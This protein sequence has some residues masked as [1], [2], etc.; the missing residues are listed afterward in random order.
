MRPPKRQFPTVA[1][2]GSFVVRVSFESSPG[3]PIENVRDWLVAWMKDQSDGHGIGEFGS[4][5]PFAAYFS[6][7]PQ[8]ELG[9]LGEL[10]LLLRGVS[11]EGDGRFWKDWYVHISRALLARF[12]GLRGVERIVSLQ[13]A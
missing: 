13:S 6:A 4:S 10:T 3:E 8:A 2:D 7:P 1:P 11:D 12:P 5:R 9:S